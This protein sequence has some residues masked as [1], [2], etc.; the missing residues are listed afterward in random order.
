MNNNTKGK[1]IATKSKTRK[2]SKRADSKTGL[3]KSK[4][5]EKKPI[6]EKE[7]SQ[8]QILMQQE[9]TRLESALHSEKEQ[10]TLKENELLNLLALEKE[11]SQENQLFQSQVERLQNIEKELMRVQTQSQ[12]D[13]ARLESILHS[14][15][16]KSETLTRH[17]EDLNESKNNLSRNLKREQEERA[18]QIAKTLVL[19]KQ[20]QD[21][22]LTI[23][24]LL[25]QKMVLESQ[26]QDK[27]QQIA[28]E[29][30]RGLGEVLTKLSALAEKEPESVRGLKPRAVYETLLSWLEKTFGER[31]KMFPS[32]REFTLTADGKYLITL[33][34][35]ADGIEALLKRYDWAHEHPFENKSEGQRQC[36]FKIIQWGWKVSDTILVRA[37]VTIWHVDQ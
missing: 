37:N 17:I 19:D 1:K 21:G 34:A 23:E 27:K 18:A 33:D 5:N 11:R 22:N 10:F 12:Q 8:E 26:F 7:L 13:I 6:I 14:E 3:V 28:I 36:R 24:N 32:S 9:I 2:P 16:E 15:K 20:L 29:W 4:K 35:D 25:N 31:P 30:A